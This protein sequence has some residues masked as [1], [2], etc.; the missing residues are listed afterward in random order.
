MSDEITTETK[1]E[2]RL[3]DETINKL[4]ASLDALKDVVTQPREVAPTAVR[5]EPV[6]DAI[7]FDDMDLD[8]E[9]AEKLTKKLHARDA[10]LKSEIIEDITGRYKVTTTRNNVLS[11]VLKDYP[12]MGDNKSQL[13]READKVMRERMTVDNTYK[14]GIFA[15]QDCTIEAARRINYKPRSAEDRRLSGLTGGYTETTSSQRPQTPQM[16]AE[17]STYQ[18]K[19]AERMGVPN[20]VFSKNKFEQDAKGVYRKIS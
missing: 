7:D 19:V 3:T 2:A 1:P 17:I 16:Q 11:S 13:W 6:I 8:S 9:Q 18:M 14:D 10:N 15:V 4:A 5:A 12:E 20:D